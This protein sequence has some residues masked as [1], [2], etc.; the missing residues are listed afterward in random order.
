MAIRPL[1]TLILGPPRFTT[2]GEAGLLWYSMDIVSDACLDALYRGM[3]ARFPEYA[4]EDALVELAKDR[5]VVRGIGESTASW[6]ARCKRWLDDARHRGSPFMLMQK[7][8]EYI[9]AGSSFRIVDVA[10]NWW[11]RS[12]AGVETKLLAQGNWNWDSTVS[13]S[14]WSRFWVIIYPGTRFTVTTQIWGDGSVW[15]D[16]TKCWGVSGTPDQ[17]QTIRDIVA[18]WKPNGTKCDT[19]IY[20]FDAASFNPASP[21]PDGK[22]G[23]WYKVVAGVNVPSRLSTARYAEGV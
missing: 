9:G 5:R 22:W 16:K 3:L 21:E 4:E 15:G 2:K 19:I 13:A 17:H 23:K 11:S 10:G 8:S 1:R 18:D 20:A 14:N 12:A 6:A 7:L